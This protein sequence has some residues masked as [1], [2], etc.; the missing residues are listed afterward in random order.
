MA[1]WLRWWHGTVTD[2]KFLWVAR[3]AGARLGDVLAV[4][5][6]LLEEASQAAE[7]GYVVRFDADSFDCLLGTDDGE[8][9]RI[10]DAMAAK[11]LIDQDGR[12][13]GWDSRQPNRED[14]GSPTAKSSTARSREHRARKRGESALRETP[15]N[16]LQRDAT[17]CNAQEESR[18][19]ERRNTSSPSSVVADSTAIAGDDPRP[20]ALPRAVVIAAE[21]TRRGTVCQLLRAAGV[22]D[23]APHHLTDETWAAI[24]VK[25]TDEEI[26]EFA[27]SKLASR[28]DQRTGLKY[29]A[30]GLLEDPKP[31]AMPTAG[32]R[33]SPRPMT[34]EEG[35]AIAA[36]T[37]LSDFRA[38][39]AADRGQDDERT[40]EAAAAPR[41]LG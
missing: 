25:R 39:C 36:S 9:S 31:L 24:L 13:S 8:V 14:S 26:V 35:R 16:D 2:T 10:I 17:Q 37:R 22:A 33:A 27:R 4:W 29:L 18:G 5:S 20:A 41:Q 30:P 40:I 11:G 6:A 12:L 32:A 28:P 23:A 7:R 3:R 1:D 21:P 38:A 34:R 19:E 15:R